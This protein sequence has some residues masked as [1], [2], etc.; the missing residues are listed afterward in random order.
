MNDVK[1]LLRSG[2]DAD[3][4]ERWVLRPYI[5]SVCMHDTD[6]AVQRLYRQKIMERS[7]SKRLRMGD[8][9]FVSA[10]AIVLASLSDVSKE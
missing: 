8:G 1:N 10:R 4:V 5:R 7:G 3:Y 6:S 9:M 2:Y